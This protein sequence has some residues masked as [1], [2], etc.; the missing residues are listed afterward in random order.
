MLNLI[1]KIYYTDKYCFGYCII[2]FIILRISS[3]IAFNTFFSWLQLILRLIVI[4]KYL[5]LSISLIACLLGF[6]NINSNYYIMTILQR[7]K[8]IYQYGKI[9]GTTSKDKLQSYINM[10][11][12]VTVN[13]RFK[14]KW[15]YTFTHNT[16]INHLQKNKDV[17]VEIIHKAYKD[18]LK[19]L[20]WW[21]FKNVEKDKYYNMAKKYAYQN[22]DYY[23]VKLRF[24]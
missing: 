5:L 21:H 23:L 18:N 13:K 19:L 1:K 17:E 2:L 9:K 15:L 12:N 14:N 8:M 3:F 11:N 6:T 10:A 16:V 24:V 22:R 7:K 4:I 20:F